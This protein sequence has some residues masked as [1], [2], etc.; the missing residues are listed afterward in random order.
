MGVESERL[1]SVFL[2]KLQPEEEGL[3]GTRGGP[4]A[5]RAEGLVCPR[6]HALE[7]CLM[8]APAFPE[9]LAGQDI[10]DLGA[11]PGHWPEAEAFGSG[12]ASC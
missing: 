5:G 6:L 1:S 3:G 8:G 4:K 2:S 9:A 7:C 11:D 12:G 10:V